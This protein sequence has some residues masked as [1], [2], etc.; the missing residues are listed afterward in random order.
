[1]SPF[2]FEIMFEKMDLLERLDISILWGHYEISVLRF[3]L[4]SFPPGKVIDFHNHAEFE[5]HFIPRAR[6][7]SFLGIS[8]ILYRRECSI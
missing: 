1:M 5:F 8:S 6:E 7:R 3:H 4:T 2:P